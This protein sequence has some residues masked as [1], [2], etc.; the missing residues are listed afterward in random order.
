MAGKNQFLECLSLASSDSEDLDYKPSDDLNTSSGSSCGSLTNDDTSLSSHENLSTPPNSLVDR[1]FP[2]SKGNALPAPR[3]RQS[4]TESTESQSEGP[5]FI[6]PQ[7]A[8]DIPSSLS[9]LSSPLSTPSSTSSRSDAID[10]APRLDKGKGRAT[11]DALLQKQA[12]DHVP[13]QEP[14]PVKRGHILFNDALELPP[15]ADPTTCLA[16]DFATSAAMA[17]KVNFPSTPLPLTR[18]KATLKIGEPQP[19]GLGGRHL[20][21]RDSGHSLEIKFMIP[22]DHEYTDG[23]ALSD[24]SHYEGMYMK[25]AKNRLMLWDWETPGATIQLIVNL[26]YAIM[27]AQHDYFQT[28]ELLPHYRMQDTKRFDPFHPSHHIITGPENLHL[29]SIFSPDNGET[30]RT[31]HAIVEDPVALVAAKARALQKTLPPTVWSPRPATRGEIRRCAL[32]KLKINKEIRAKEKLAQQ[33]AEKAA[34]AER[35]ARRAKMSALDHATA[36]FGLVPCNGSS[37]CRCK[38]QN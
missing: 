34:K 10:G 21:V 12:E 38:R 18:F 26:A 3:V 30:W 8:L 22:K 19:N 36:T 29:V 1:E 6:W 2:G 24:I 32:L 23:V 15:C 9:S 28:T 35:N 33:A 14:P 37:G 25:G 4:T 7:P 11:D 31:Q 13:Q 20:L 16:L 17:Q 27:Q 5:N